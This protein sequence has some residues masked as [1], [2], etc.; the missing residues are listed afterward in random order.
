MSNFVFISP[1]VL[2]ANVSMI[3][4]ARHRWENL[5]GFPHLLTVGIFYDLI[6][7]Y[8]TIESLYLYSIGI[9]GHS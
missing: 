7:K 1:A 5:G 3:L 6:Q 4:R 8:S 9:F 2:S